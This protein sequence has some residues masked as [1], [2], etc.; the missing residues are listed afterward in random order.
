MKLAPI[1]VAI[2]LATQV[3]TAWAATTA[4]AAQPQFDPVEL[5][6]TPVVSPLD[7]EVRIAD[8]ERS[9][10]RIQAEKD[11][12]TRIAA[13]HKSL[14]LLDQINLDRPDFTFA[15]GLAILTTGYID[16]LNAGRRK[17]SGAARDRNL[18]EAQAMVLR[19]DDPDARLTKALDIAQID[20]DS[21]APEQALASLD[22]VLADSRNLPTAQR[23]AALARAITIAARPD[24]ELPP[25]AILWL[26]DIADPGLRARSLRQIALA[27]AARDAVL[28][29]L[30][31]SESLGA[32]RDARLLDISDFLTRNGRFDAATWS[33]AL[34]SDQV[35]DE[36]DAALALVVGDMI[37]A[38]IA[39][40]PAVHGIAAVTVRNRVLLDLVIHYLDRD[41]LAEARRAAGFQTPGIEAALAWTR[42][43]LRLA[44]E[45]YRQQAEAA[46]DR[47]EAN[48]AATAPTQDARHDTVRGQLVALTAQLGRR[49][50]ARA[51][52]ATIADAATAAEIRVGLVE[53]ALSQNALDEALTELTHFD[54]G[55][56]RDRAGVLCVSALAGERRWA[57]AVALAQQIP[58]PLARLDALTGL[59]Q[60]I[61]T[62]RA[63]KPGQ[64][65]PPEVPGLA[66]E[67]EHWAERAAQSGARSEASARRA[68]ARAALGAFA[69]ARTDLDE[70]TAAERYGDALAYVVKQQTQIEGAEPALQT[71][72]LVWRK[73]SRPQAQAVVATAAAKRG[74]IETAVAIARGLD[75]ELLR[76]ET[77]RKIAQETARQRDDYDLFSA[78]G[79]GETD[80]TA[81]DFGKLKKLR[82]LGSSNGTQL[83]AMRNPDL[84]R[85]L[86]PTPSLK[87][88]KHVAVAADIP[89]IAPGAIHVMPLQYSDFNTKFLAAVLT[90]DDYGGRLF[91]FDAQKETA[92]PVFLSLNDG[93]F[94]LSSIARHLRETGQSQHLAQEGRR[95]T[96]N[97]PLLVGP[98]ATLVISGADVEEL[99]LNRNS[100]AYLVNAGRLIVYNTRITGWDAT[101]QAPAPLDYQ[102]RASFRPFIAAWG[103]SITDIARS[104]ITHLGFAGTKAYGLTYSSGPEVLLKNQAIGLRRPTGRVIDNSFQHMLY[105]FYSYEADDV[106][107]VGNEY[108]DNL[109]YGI[110]P[111]DY[112]RRLLIG[113]NTVYGTAIKHGIIVSR[114][115]DDSWIVGNL[116]FDNR[117]SGVMLDRDSS[118]NL[119]YANAVFGNHQD[120]I[121]LFES[122]CNI[123]AA[124]LLRGNRRDGIRSRNSWDIGLFGN[125][126]A[127]N[128]GS[129]ISSYTADLAA[130]SQTSTRNLV[131]D[132]YT[133]LADLALVDNT[134]RGNRRGGL[135][136]QNVANLTWKG[137][138]LVAQ[139]KPFIG[140]LKDFVPELFKYSDRGLHLRNGCPETPPGY[141]CTFKTQGFLAGSG[142]DAAIG[143]ADEILA[144]KCATAIP[145]PA[146]PMQAATLPAAAR[147]AT[148]EDR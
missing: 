50:R 30:M 124:N 104:I 139:P 114:E 2:L 84:G 143:T 11:S 92:F 131:L 21:G 129:A 31:A 100:G 68:M 126:V 26:E 137:N 18:G 43:G 52:L 110:D 148:H 120:G 29:K 9:L 40:I 122:S 106:A 90:P 67:I 1:S 81:R 33:A 82:L 49:E 94:D 62:G 45:N 57:E 12:G 23:D 59:L 98:N 115:V 27:S 89:E 56:A 39:I 28:S 63:L 25:R 146:I 132:P 101:L 6:T 108:R 60:R 130:N 16:E 105:G 93:V 36:R 140:A 61:D 13:Y 111:H 127:E 134:V 35:G 138:A 83:S 113:Y 10:A 72:A 99:R 24:A 78:A 112:S 144:S 103:G 22:R 79:A 32:D 66:R 8:F 19:L 73:N 86:P 58:S 133:K 20:A 44:H 117:G 96:F 37:E 102:N 38:K 85:T 77:F 125:V 109:V 34:A 95:Y 135:N 4:G 51:L 3:G 121:V 15:P 5:A 142:V 53:S 88:F 14:E 46:A 70:A 48:L 7:I 87:G 55:A 107:V 71:A 128:Q 116:S 123:V 42:I 64:Q 17:L 76:V 47:A 80:E 74:E 75:D 136:L 119:I 141:H 69:Q 97:L 118:G 147:V 91:Y 65:V 145:T 41:Q 54:P